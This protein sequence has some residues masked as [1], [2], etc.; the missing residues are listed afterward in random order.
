VI[1]PEV[2][3][4]LSLVI[5]NVKRESWRLST[6]SPDPKIL[7]AAGCWLFCLW[8]CKQVNAYGVVF[9]VQVWDIIKI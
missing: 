5:E 7:H 8:F 3:Y 6:S 4:E 9:V 1:F 2:D